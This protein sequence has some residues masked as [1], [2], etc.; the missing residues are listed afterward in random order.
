MPQER[1]RAARRACC[2]CLAFLLVSAGCAT[3]TDWGPAVPPKITE[4]AG[5]PPVNINDDESM[6]DLHTLKDNLFGLME[7]EVV[8]LLDLILDTLT[9]G[10]PVRPLDTGIQGI[11]NGYSTLPDC[12]PKRTVG[13]LFDALGIHKLSYSRQLGFVPRIVYLIDWIQSDIFGALNRGGAWCKYTYWYKSPEEQ[14]VDQ[15]IPRWVFGWLNW[16]VDRGEEGLLVSYVFVLEKLN[17]G[18]DKGISGIEWGVNGLCNGTC[19]VFTLGKT[20]VR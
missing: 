15:L 3:Y 2:L 5:T 20:R 13:N 9:P 11:A 4:P 8:R 10:A 1:N 7:L 16:G 6:F 14:A 17:F 19:W 12:G 18:L